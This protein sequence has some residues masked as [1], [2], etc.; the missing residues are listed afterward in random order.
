MDIILL[1]ILIISITLIVSVILSVILLIWF[2]NQIDNFN[3]DV[4]TDEEL[5]ELLNIK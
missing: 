2:A 5:K 3:E 4:K 1:I